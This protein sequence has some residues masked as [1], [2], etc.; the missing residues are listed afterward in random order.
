M[1]N[2]HIKISMLMLSACWIGL[3]QSAVADEIRLRNGD[4]ITGTIVKKETTVVVF[5][6][7]YAGDINVQ[8]SEIISLE[9]DKPV[10]VVLS[11]GSNLRGPVEEVE[12]GVAKIELAKVTP[13]EG[14]EKGPEEDD[15]PEEKD[16]DMREVRYI[17]PS[18]DLTG[19]GVRWTGNLS[20]GGSLTEGNTER[21]TL[22]FDGETIARTLK[23]RYSLN[24]IFNRAEDFDRN[25]E[26]NSRVFGK[27]DRFFTE[28][29]YG[30]VN[31]SFENDR[32][33]DLRLRMMAGAGSGYQVFETPN[34]NL[35][36]EAGLNYIRENHYV[37]ENE[38][39]PGIRWAVKYDHLVFSGKVRLFHEHE[40]LVGF[41]DTSHVL[42]FSKTGLR[43]P[44]VFNMNA[45][46]QYNYNWDSEPAE[47]L[48]KA[49]STL[50]FTVGYGW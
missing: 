8:W 39:Y 24:G 45:S 23:N 16:F 4:V 10:H 34:L 12:P 3:S 26:F 29:W 14:S 36:L 25:T 44:L 13:E 1:L 22:R 9:S 28:Q 18:P 35:S 15:I 17:N 30:Y 5:R 48:E 31:T 37:E 19:E 41:E 50:M 6:T 49:D 27:Y 21:K 43:F 46:A 7:T 38:S 2:K 32:F 20:A 11:D 42:V 33:R 40:T 47:G